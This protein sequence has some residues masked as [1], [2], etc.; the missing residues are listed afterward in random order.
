[1]DR[2]GMLFIIIGLVCL[3]ITINPD[4]S[5]GYGVGMGILILGILCLYNH[6]DTETSD[7]KE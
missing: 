5:F 3:M 7:V 1:M 6:T 4:K 2:T